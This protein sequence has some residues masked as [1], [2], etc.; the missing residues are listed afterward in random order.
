MKKGYEK[1]G[2]P[3]FKE[4]SL[5]S[6]ILSLCGNIILALYFAFVKLFPFICKILMLLL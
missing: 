6:E 3:L 2:I 1:I 4:K 5:H